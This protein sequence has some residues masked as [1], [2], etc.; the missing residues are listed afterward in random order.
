[1]KILMLYPK[2][3][4]ATFWNINHSQWKFERRKSNLPPLGLL[5]IASYLPQDFE[6]RL[7]DRN[8]REESEQD[9]QWADVV[10]LSLMGVQKE[11]Y[12]LCI[13][14]AKGLAKPVAVG[15]PYTHAFPEE[16]L[17]DADWVCFGEI[18]NI[19]QEFIADLRA[20]RRGKSYQGGNKTDME[21]VPV[22]RYELLEDIQEYSAMAVQFSR[23]CPFL[24]EFCDII[25]IYGR[26][27]RTKNPDQILRELDVIQKL[28][29]TGYVFIVD[30]NF[31]GNKK[32]AVVM[33]HELAAWNKKQPFSYKFFT[34]ASINLADEED[35]LRAM[36]DSNMV[37]V[38]IGIETPDPVLLKAMRKYQNVAGNP[39]EKLNKI[40]QYG[41][42]I[43]AGFIL[44]FDG[45]KAGVFEAQKEF[46]QASGIGVAM[47]GLLMALPHT[48]L[49]RRLKKEGRLLEKFSPMEQT[50]D[51]I[52]YIP[53]GDI[54]KRDY[55]NRYS[56]LIGEVYAPKNFFSRVLP[57]YMS[58]RP[59]TAP[60]KMTLRLIFQ[61]L[62]ILFR[63][64]YYFGVRE[65]GSRR[66]YWKTLFTLL[67]KNAQAIRAFGMD[68]ILYYHL[69]RHAIFAQNN[70]HQ[71]VQNPLPEDILDQKYQEE[72]PAAEAVGY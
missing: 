4:T 5:T 3:P 72:M 14:K 42:H 49:S 31:I 51:G 45:E 30:D 64:L 19:V 24:C 41:I 2:Y 40:R 26:V 43:T 69:K 33:L 46:I 38:F 9:W 39:L 18:E 58:L 32:K 1:M 23:G 48:Q 15:G 20:D 60:D 68:C 27:P 37:M 44:G 61:D 12:R 36:S 55:L 59:K 47:L 8:I 63:Q 17:A 22:P 34:E 16:A 71:Y 53:K 10:F 52:N 65:K 35:L 66:Y 28:G 50:V 57:A 6:I 21:A 11:D 62:F 56:E 67:F 29:F 70:L 25:E 13:A 54:T 7:I